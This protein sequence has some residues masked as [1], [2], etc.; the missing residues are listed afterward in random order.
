MWQPIPE[1]PGLAEDCVK[2][3]SKDQN[4]NP[5]IS[6]AQVIRKP[7]MRRSAGIGLGDCIGGANQSWVENA[8]VFPARNGS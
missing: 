8:M 4:H 6:P 2:Q 1:Y 5:A 7:G 3:E